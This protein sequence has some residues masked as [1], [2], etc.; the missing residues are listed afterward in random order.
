MTVCVQY[1]SVVGS[2]LLIIL[3][4]GFHD[5]YMPYCSAD[6]TLLLVLPLVDSFHD[7]CALYCSADGTVLLILPLVNGFPNVSRA[8]FLSGWQRIAWSAAC[9]RFRSLGAVLL[10]VERWIAHSSLHPRLSRWFTCRITHSSG[11][12]RLS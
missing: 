1:C 7:T 9:R 12:L 5:G 3:A 4:S 2:K 10:S 11:H 8:V 6:G